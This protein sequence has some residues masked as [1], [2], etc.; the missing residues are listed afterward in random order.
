MDDPSLLVAD[1]EVGRRRQPFGVREHPDEF[2]GPE[3]SLQLPVPVVQGE[4]RGAVVESG[5]LH[6][7]PAPGTDQ[8]EARLQGEE[9]ARLTDLVGGT[10]AAVVLA[11]VTSL[12]NC[13]SWYQLMG[14][15]TCLSW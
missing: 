7:L 12:F 3:G 13:S 9:S 4:P 11:S 6:P 14:A 15:M 10:G 8:R 2:T 5:E 1:R